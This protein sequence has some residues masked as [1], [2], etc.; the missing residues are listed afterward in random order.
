MSK[1]QREV[2]L[3]SYKDMLKSDNPT[4]L[5]NFIYNLPCIVMLTYP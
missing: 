5:D 1:S 2:V 3:N 4:V